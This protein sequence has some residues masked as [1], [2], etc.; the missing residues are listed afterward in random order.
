[1]IRPV[2]NVDLPGIVYA[3]DRRAR[4][5]QSEFA[6]FVVAP[7]FEEQRSPLAALL[8]ALLP[9]TPN[10]HTWICEDRWRLLGLAQARRR[11]GAR[12]WDLAYLAAITNTAANAFAQTLAAQAAQDDVLFE[13]LQYT[14]DAAMRRGVDRV[15]AR[16][17][18]ER[19]ELEIFGKLGFQR[20]ARELTYWLDSPAEGLERLGPPSEREN[21]LRAHGGVP[22]RRLAEVTQ[23][24]K[25]S[26]HSEPRRD[27]AH[28]GA[29]V[30]RP[31][32]P[33]R[34]WHRHDAWGLLRLYDA[35]TPRRVQLAENLTS[36]EF[37]QT[38]AAGGRTWFFPLLEPP[39]EAFTCD[40]GVRLGGW[41]RLRH[42]RGSQPHM[43][44]IMAHPDDPGVSSALVRFGLRVFATEAARP[45]F[46]QVRDYESPVVDALRAAGFDHIGAHAL[47]VRQLTLRALRKREVPATEARIAY[48]LRGLGTAPARLSKGD[49]THYARTQTR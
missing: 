22:A 37:V 35:C 32:V 18:D 17:E 26:D 21:A 40:R 29:S 49:K 20:Y 42:G 33:L 30:I 24:H 5:R 47:L 28:D 34:R 13:L 15:F 23:E 10:A 31:E 7:D 14:L 4:S 16:V 2:L 38:R 8:S 25:K 11:G 46:C 36:E 44:S 43:L 27:D 39:S 48:G 19:P 12:A 45:V 9:I 1:M 3:L 6:N 41:I